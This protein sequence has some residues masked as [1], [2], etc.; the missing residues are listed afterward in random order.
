VEALGR[1]AAALTPDL[2]GTV[3]P[4]RPPAARRRA[5]ERAAEQLNN[6]GI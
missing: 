1:F 5:S 4:P 2:G 6:L 3:L